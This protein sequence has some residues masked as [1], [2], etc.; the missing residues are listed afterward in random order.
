MLCTAAQT[1]D[2]VY[3]NRETSALFLKAKLKLAAKDL[4]PVPPPLTLLS[5][6]AYAV[7]FVI[8]QCTK[9]SAKTKVEPDTGAPAAAPAAAP[10]SKP[11][12]RWLEVDERWLKAAQDYVDD[13][14]GQDEGAEHWRRDFSKKLGQVEKKLELKIEKMQEEIL[15]RLPSPGKPFL[16]ARAQS[17]GPAAPPKTKTRSSTPRAQSSE[18]EAASAPGGTSDGRADRAQTPRG[19]SRFRMPRVYPPCNQPMV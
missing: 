5:I 6:P 13:H 18:A 7:E 11:S 2:I 19:G 4:P 16:K 9:N 12:R 14:L 1:F 3:D 15:R 10:A 17:A 8:N